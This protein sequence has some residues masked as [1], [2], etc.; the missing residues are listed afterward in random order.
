MMEECFAAS[1]YCTLY[2]RVTLSSAMHTCLWLLASWKRSWAIQR[3]AAGRNIESGPERV[4][5]RLAPTH[6]IS[7]KLLEIVLLVGLDGDIGGG[8]GDAGQAV[9]AGKKGVLTRHLQ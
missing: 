6:C 9:A 8:L 3:E 1:N 5:A 4:Y 7:V 2:L